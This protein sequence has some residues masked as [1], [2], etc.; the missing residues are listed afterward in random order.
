M[1]WTQGRRAVGYFMTLSASD[2]RITHESQRIWKEEGV[3]QL[4]YYPGIFLGTDDNHKYLILNSWCPGQDS[5][6]P[7][8]K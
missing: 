1:V 4:R 7:P 8:P 6:E 5:K 2:G 3:A